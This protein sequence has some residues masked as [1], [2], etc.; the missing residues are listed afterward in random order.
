MPEEKLDFMVQGKIN[1]GRYT[2][3]PDGRQSI[4]TKQCPPPPFLANLIISTVAPCGSG[5][6]SKWVSVLVSSLTSLF[7]TNMAI[8]ETRVTV[9]LS[10]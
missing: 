2:D 8:S 10:K 9:Y 4:R 3:H 7:S 1:R 5:A 6:V